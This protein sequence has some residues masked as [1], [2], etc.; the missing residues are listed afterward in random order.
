MILKVLSILFGVIII[1]FG[2]FIGIKN[3]IIKERIIKSSVFFYIFFIELI[4]KIMW[5]KEGFSFITAICISAILVIFIFYAKAYRVYGASKEELTELLA[6]FF[7]QKSIPWTIEEDTLMIEH[8]K[9]L[10]D[11]KLKEVFKRTTIY[12]FQLENDKLCYKIIEEIKNYIKEKKENKF[13]YE[14]I[15]YMVLGILLILLGRKL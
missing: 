10:I 14:I 5:G 12:L 11:I 6:D 4:L 8:R 1:L 15:I 7:S 3:F 13:S 9:R 2:M